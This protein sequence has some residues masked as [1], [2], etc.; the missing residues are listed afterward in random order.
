MHVRDVMRPMAEPIDSSDSAQTAAERMRSEDTGCLMVGDRQKIVGMVT[1]RDL[2][3]R[4]VAAGKKPS[5]T[6]V[7][8][9]MSVGVVV[10]REDETVGEVVERMMELG[11]MRLPVLDGEGQPVG[12]VSARDS[13]RSV[14]MS[15]VARNKPA[16]AHFFKEIPSSSG[17]MHRVPVHS[18]YVT[19]GEGP[20]GTEK[21]AIERLQADRGV[22][23]WSVVADGLEIDGKGKG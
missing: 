15:K 7:R 10:C 16:V 21:E 6:P 22:G 17:H 23:D 2:A 11:L 13:V 1:D 19:E 9:I 14:P 4:C 5:N 20:D 12:M 8:D 3:I 18:V